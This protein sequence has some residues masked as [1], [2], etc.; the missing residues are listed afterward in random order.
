MSTWKGSADA[1]QETAGGGGGQKFPPAPRGFYTIQVADVKE[2]KTKESNRDKV[3]LECE[4]ADEGPE[5]GKKVWVTITQI[6]KDEKGHGM[7]IHA[8]HAFGIGLDGDYEFDPVS[9]LQGKSARALLGVEPR[10][11][12]INKGTP[13]E[14][15]FINDVNFVEALYTEKHPEPAE[16]PAPRAPKAAPTP[17][18]APSGAKVSAAVQQ[19]FGK[20]AAAGAKKAGVPF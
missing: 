17:A 18:A 9:D 8:L 14:K 15:T 6:P 2:G 3:D 7:M 12:T 1:E 13:Q 11:K 19:T 16:L 20:P 10:P 4:I 5:F